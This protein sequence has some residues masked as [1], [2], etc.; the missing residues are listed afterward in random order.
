MIAAVEPAQRHHFHRHADQERGAERQQ[1]AGDEAAG[2]GREGRREIGA[3]HV[4]RAMREIH[5][6]HD[7][8]DERE[9]G[10]EQEQQQPEL[11]TVQALFDETT[12]SDCARGRWMAELGRSRCY[13]A[14]C[15]LVPPALAAVTTSSGT[16]RETGPGCP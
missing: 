11:Q 15:P 7:A 3:Q 12:A 1:R 4:E 2:P 6:V 16:C 10:G 13:V 14:A 8:E 9:A 5:Q